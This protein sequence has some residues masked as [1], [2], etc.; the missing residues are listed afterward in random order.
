MQ[1]AGCQHDSELTAMVARHSTEDAKNIHM[2]AFQTSE[3]PPQNS[4]RRLRYAD[5]K[6]R[7]V[8]RG[9]LHA[10]GS[11]TLMFGLVFSI[12]TDLP[13]GLCL[14]LAGK[15]CCYTASAVF[16][17]VDFAST[18][19]VTQAF[20]VDILAVP[21]SVCGAIAPFVPSNLALREMLIAIGVVLLNAVCVAWQTRGQVGLKTPSGLTDAARSV[22]VAM[23]SLYVFGFLGV[24]AG[25]TGLWIPLLVLTA[26]AIA[27][28]HPVTAA[29]KEEPLSQQVP[30][31][32]K[33]V[34]SFHED[35]HLTLAASDVTWFL[36]A[37]QH[38][39]LL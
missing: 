26:V 6:P 2:P 20:V 13:G 24:Q 36:F 31:H 17:V 10:L 19:R 32:T 16:H 28:S 21:L 27:V 15:L 11:V 25:F 8:C 7:P 33:H 38:H 34:W 37:L 18:E 29:H 4:C 14:G 35:F 1:D 12:C 39:N 9:V 3:Q 5:G 22:V 23:Y 30:W